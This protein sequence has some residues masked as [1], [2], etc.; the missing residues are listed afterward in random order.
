M[1]HGCKQ[2]VFKLALQQLLV[3][4]SRSI[5]VEL[6]YRDVTRPASDADGYWP[7]GVFRLRKSS[8]C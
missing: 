2:S 7:S 8:H 5:F 6:D 4:C 3:H 1:G